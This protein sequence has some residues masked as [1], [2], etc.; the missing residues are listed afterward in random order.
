MKLK[1]FYNK[2]KE[3]NDTVY[4]EGS[5]IILF[6]DKVMLVVDE[7]AGKVHYQP[8][9]TLDL[10]EETLDRIDYLTGDQKRVEEYVEILAKRVGKLLDKSAESGNNSLHVR[11]IGSELSITRMYGVDVI[12]LNGKEVLSVGKD[13]SVICKINDK[14]LLNVLSAFASEVNT[15]DTTMLSLAV[16]N[17]INN[18]E[19]IAEKSYIENVD[20]DIVLKWDYD[21][22]GFPYRFMKS[23]DD[24]DELVE[25]MKVL[26]LDYA[27]DVFGKVK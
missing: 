26:G 3:C 11:V 23:L 25:S 15:K 18:G 22:D 2:Y 7:A 9:G 8:W 27:S 1:E 17:L 12:H 6:D 14:E 4:Q 20:G 24:D 21:G 13:N 5:G 10:T 16:V 19:I